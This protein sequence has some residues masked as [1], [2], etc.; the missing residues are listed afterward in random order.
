[1]II[2]DIGD[3]LGSPVWTVLATLL[4]AAA[5]WVSI[6]LYRR[7]R[8]RKSLSYEIS[9]TELVSVHSA[10]NDAKD[11]IRIFFDEEQ[12]EQV[13]L[14]EARIENNGNVPVPSSDFEG[15]LV[16]ELGE[17]A[18]PLTVDVTNKTT[19]DLHGEAA[20]RKTAVALAPLLLNPG[21][22]LTL[23]ILT[24]NLQRKVE[25]HYRIVGVTEMTD[26]AAQRE[27]QGQRTLLK[28][29]LGEMLDDQLLS[30]AVG[31]L[32]VITVLFG[33][34][35]LFGPDKKTEAVITLAGGQ[36]LC[37]EVLE[38]SDKRLIVQL[39]DSGEIRP[40]EI[41]EVESVKDDAC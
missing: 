36:E 18:A 1:M 6:W 14:V 40:L 21:D 32:L 4:A 19:P 8:T 16:I 29:V 10:A 24:R 34:T 30:S 25:C 37:G 13:H 11:R 31:G 7:Q 35:K 2:A 15:P 33:I 27:S 38:T 39:A 41:E 22:G 23:K 26:A 12:I 20:Y 28:K 5:I 3:I 9:V 17:G